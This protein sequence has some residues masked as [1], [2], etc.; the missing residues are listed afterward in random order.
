[1][2]WLNKLVAIEAGVEIGLAC[3]NCLYFWG[4]A[5]RTRPAARKTAAMALFCVSA[6]FGS[7]ALLFLSFEQGAD[8]PTWQLGATAFVR[9][10]LLAGCALLSLLALRATWNG[11]GREG[12]HDNVRRGS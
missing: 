1:V 8:L 2:Q 7:E 10:T 12:R 5:V 4:Y 11:A 3:L 9:T 6:G